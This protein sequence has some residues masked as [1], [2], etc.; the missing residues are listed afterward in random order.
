MVISDTT[1]WWG[2]SKWKEEYIILGLVEDG[3]EGY[4]WRILLL[5]RLTTINLPQIPLRCVCVC[6]CVHA[7]S[8]RHLSPSEIIGTQATGPSSTWIG[9]EPATLVLV[10][11]SSL[12]HVSEEL[13]DWSHSCSPSLLWSPPSGAFLQLQSRLPGRDQERNHWGGAHLLLWVCGMSWWGV[14]RRDR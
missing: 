2:G 13:E 5:C 8:H 1:M 12:W 10:P 4:L 14:Q 11:S 9:P 6:V 7:L 3:R